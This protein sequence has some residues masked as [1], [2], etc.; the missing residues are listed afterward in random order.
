M[1]PLLDDGKH[2]AELVRQYAK[3]ELADKTARILTTATLLAVMISIGAL[4]L[5]CIT[6]ACVQAVEQLTANKILSYAIVAL[7]LILLMAIIALLR[8]EIIIRPIVR[9]V[10]SIFFKQSKASRD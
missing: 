5:L 4:V 10:M 9:K 1:S 6:L 3:L 7:A 2:L 8:R